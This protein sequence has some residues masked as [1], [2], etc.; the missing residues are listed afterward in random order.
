MSIFCRCS[1]A[2]CDPSA[3]THWHCHLQMF[4]FL[5]SVCLPPAF[6]AG[7]LLKMEGDV[8]F[9]NVGDFQR[10]C[11]PRRIL[12]SVNPSRSNLSVYLFR[13]SAF[14]LTVSFCVYVTCAWI[15]MCWRFYCIGIIKFIPWQIKY[16]KI[17]RWL[18]R[19]DS[20]IVIETGYGLDDKG[21]GVRVPVGSRT[22]SSP[23][24]PVWI[25]VH[26]TFYEMS[27]E[28]SF[29]R[30]KEAGAWS[31]PLTSSKCWGQE[32]VDLYLHSPQTFS[33]RS[34]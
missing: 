9:R 7:I 15:H 18:R 27:N 12:S 22:F 24:R 23:C 16:I 17:P 34:A 25:W 11:I 28:G 1:V 32:N 20:V 29:R 26:P 2:Q 30:G 8:F 5:P 14:W 21:I 31:W 19:R 6:H 10:C 33:W 13:T 4:Q 3:Q